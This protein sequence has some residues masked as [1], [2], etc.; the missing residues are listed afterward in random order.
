MKNESAYVKK[1]SALYR[2]LPAAD[3]PEAHDPVTQL[4]IGFLQ[5]EATKRQAELAFKR[6]ME[7]VVDNNDL[8]VTHPQ[9]ILERI[10]V[11]YPRAEER[12]ARLRDA[13]QEIYVRG[14]A[15]TPNSIA[16]KSKKEQRE[17]FDSLPGMTSYVASMVMLLCYGAHAIPIDG[18]LADML[19]AAGVT[20]EHA[21]PEEISHFFERHFKAGDGVE[22]HA[23]LQ[24]WADKGAKRTTKTAKRTTKKA[25]AKKKAK[26]SKSAKKKPS[27]KIVK[28]K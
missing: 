25:P 27:T 7:I 14:H 28:H 19:K 23:R 8:R 24:A 15:I 3:L 11:N 16:E 10:G 21:T 13:L 4:V 17:Y 18:K 2:K 20:D 5:W 22:V 12:V 9:Q 1:L 26:T 6:L